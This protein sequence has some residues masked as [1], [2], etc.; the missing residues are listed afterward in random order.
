MTEHYPEADFDRELIPCEKLPFPKF[1][2]FRKL[3]ENVEFE[4]SQVHSDTDESVT[5]CVHL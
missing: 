5:C 2:L 4:L 3:L 1:P